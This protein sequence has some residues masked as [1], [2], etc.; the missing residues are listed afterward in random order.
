MV[1]VEAPSGKN[2]ANILIMEDNPRGYLTINNLD[3]AEYVIHIHI[4]AP[5][6]KPLDRITTK[7]NN[8][9]AEEWSKRGS[10]SLATAIN[11]ILR[12]IAWINRQARTH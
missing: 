3:L 7:V 8:T 1:C 2:I 12:K 4:F 11:P 5:L 9:V 6:M 10:V